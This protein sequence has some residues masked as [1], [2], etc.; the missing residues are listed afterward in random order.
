MAVL[1]KSKSQLIKFQKRNRNKKISLC[2]G[3]FDVVHIG[4][5]K[6]FDFAKK[7]T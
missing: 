1:I 6:H 4:H 2:H 5:L 7:V 3:V